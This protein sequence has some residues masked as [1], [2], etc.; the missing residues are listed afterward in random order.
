MS[1]D[2]AA[3]CEGVLGLKSA[4]FFYEID[5]VCCVIWWETFNYSESLWSLRRKKTQIQS[6]G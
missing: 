2:R 5:M 6:A 4:F 1:S 3:H